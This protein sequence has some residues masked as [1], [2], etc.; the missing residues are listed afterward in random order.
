M[1]DRNYI[2]RVEARLSELEDEMAT[3]SA[4][5]KAK[6]M[7]GVLQEHAHHKRLHE[8]GSRYL[9]LVESRDESRSILD[10]DGADD[11]L[12]ELAKME[13]EQAEAD[14]PKREKELMIALLPPNPDDSR[15]ILMEIRAGTGGDEA[16]L[17]AG[18]L[19]RMYSMFAE[20]QG[21]KTGIIGSSPSN[22][23]GFKEII[24]SV[25]G[26]DVFKR[27]QYESGGHRVQRIPVTE[28]GG[29]IHTSAAT[30]AVLAEAEEV[31]EIQI[32]TEDIR[33]DVYRASG[34]GGQHVN[35]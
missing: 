19:Y 7:R 8:I 5:G 6:L 28:A 22:I 34:A 33:I 30:V 14:L 4:S 9:A 31:D 10:D 13:M 20:S 27:M 32:R 35:T 25:E 18:D 29:R 1:I 15:N 23:G 24:F 11:E 2:E 26:T 12:K 3:L 16:A 21:W 17:F